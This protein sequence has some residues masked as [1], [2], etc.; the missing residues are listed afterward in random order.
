MTV[1][2]AAE[3]FQQEEVISR[4]LQFLLEVGLGY[5]RSREGLSKF[6]RDGKGF[7]RHY[8]SAHFVES[9]YSAKAN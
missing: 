4:S 2:E 3:F 1:V 7:S 5:F 8:P 9:S 6:R